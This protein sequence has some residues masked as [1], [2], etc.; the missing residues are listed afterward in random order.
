MSSLGYVALFGFLALALVHRVI[1]RRY[2]DEYVAVYGRL[3]GSNW[4]MRTD[5][6]PTVEHWRRRRL[7]VMVPE[8]LL[9]LAGMYFLLTSI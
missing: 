8:L 5:D 9:F 2:L 4:F 6:N 3:P 1:G 7:A